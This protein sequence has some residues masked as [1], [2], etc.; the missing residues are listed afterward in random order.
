[1]YAEGYLEKAAFQTSIEGTQRRLTEL[2]SEQ[3]AHEQSDRQ[4]NEL[5]LVIGRLEEFGQQVRE[6]LEASDLATRRQIITTLVKQIEVDSEQVHLVYKVES[7]PFEP[8]PTGRIGPPCWGRAVAPL[9]LRKTLRKNG[10]A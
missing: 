4:R 5:R 2:E 3:Q 10:Q 9:G 8:S 6:G 1:M 7:I